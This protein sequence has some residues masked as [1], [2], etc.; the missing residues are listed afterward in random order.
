MSLRSSNSR[1][2]THWSGER[3]Y[4]FSKPFMA[5][6]IRLRSASHR[7]TTLTPSCS[8]MQGI[9]KSTPRCP[10]PITATRIVS[11]A[12][13]TWEETTNGALDGRG[14]HRRTL[15][16]LSSIDRH[17]K[18]PSWGASSARASGL[19]N[20]TTTTSGHPYWA[21]ASL[22]FCISSYSRAVGPAT[23]PGLAAGTSLQWILAVIRF[24]AIGTVARVSDMGPPCRRPLN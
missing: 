19:K 7:A 22:G 14:R 8:S 20:Q 12:P 18:T 17:V 24:A 3:L 1:M 16:E 6:A 11:L 9:W 2:S 13:N 10:N 5:S 15:Q 23:K 21:S 4:F